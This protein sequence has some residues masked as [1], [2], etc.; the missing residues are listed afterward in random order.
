M[1]RLESFNREEI[2]LKSTEVFRAKG[3]SGTSIQDLV[4]ATGL[5]R[6]SI[7][8]SFGSKQDLYRTVLAFYEE[9]NTKQFRQVLLRSKNALEALEKILRSAVD[10]IL[11][12]KEGKGCLILN[13]KSEL[14]SSDKEIG[15]WL[16]NNQEKSIKLFADLVAEGQ[17]EGKINRNHSAISYGYSL[18]N[19]FQGLRMTGILMRDKEILEGIIRN[20]LEQLQ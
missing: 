15:T 5:N 11:L 12:D 17:K 4:D 7:Y 14:G 1:P 3:Y 20:S 13:C 9:E 8:N 18:F 2:I 16:N 10:S 19:T 6:S